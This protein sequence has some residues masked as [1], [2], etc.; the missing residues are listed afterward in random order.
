MTSP[1]PA[2]EAWA[3]WWREINTLSEFLKRSKGSLVSSLPTRDQAK[4]VVQSYFR[5]VRPYLVSLTIESVQ[6]E[7]LDWIS[8]YLL[9]LASKTNRRSTY[10]T[11]M[12]ELEDLRGQVE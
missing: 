8:Q 1:H 3:Q 2:I 11:R 10:R 6:V 9:K 4:R 7:Q 12:R 5:E